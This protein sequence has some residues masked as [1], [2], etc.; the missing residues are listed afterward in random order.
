MMTDSQERHAQVVGAG[1]VGLACALALQRRGWRVSVYEGSAFQEAAS[2]GNAGHIATEQ[3]AP[4]A[5]WANVRRLPRALFSLGGPAAFPASQYSA[6]LPFGLR[7]LASSHAA[8]LSSAIQCNRALLGAALPSWQALLQHAGASHLLS[9]LGHDIVWESQVSAQ[10]G[11]Q[12]WLQADVGS[13]KVQPL[14]DSRLQQLR[15]CFGGKAYAGA[16]VQGSAQITDLGAAHQALQAHFIALGGQWQ[17]TAVARVERNGQSAQLR[18]ADGSAAPPAQRIVVAAGVHSASLLADTFGNF[19]LISERG[20]HL[21]T[22]GWPNAS[23]APATLNRPVVFED[24]SLI[25][26]PYAHGLRMASFT[27]FGHAA[28]APDPRKWQRLRQHAQALGWQVPMA[29]A[30]EW[31][32]SRPTLPDYMPA[33]GASMS[34]PNLLVAFG[35]NHLGLTLAARTAELVAQ[36]AQ[37]KALEPSMQAVLAPQRYLPKF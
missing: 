37:G 24:R 22:Q 31:S 13:C 29:T 30:T 26:T 17:S 8:R 14:A 2:F 4:L 18:L 23:G 33:I 20:Y 28:A 12:A 9:T 35:H 27:E 15:A 5:S 25:F 19:P 21:Q 34:T 16:S 7:L 32:G 11:L 10:R 6:W 3:I 36:L 1:F